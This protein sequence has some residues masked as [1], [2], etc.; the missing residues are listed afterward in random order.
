MNHLPKFIF[1]DRIEIRYRKHKR[2]NAKIYQY[3]QEPL[4]NSRMK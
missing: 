1:A 4:I 3:Q 2:D